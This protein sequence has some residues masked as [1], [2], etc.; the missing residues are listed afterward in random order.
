MPE[1]QHEGSKFLRSALS[2]RMKKGVF[3]VTAGTSDHINSVAPVTSLRGVLFL[4]I[5]LST[6]KRQFLFFHTW[7]LTD[8]RWL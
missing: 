8:V 4:S 3:L 5:A 7:E 1:S 6:I 2:L